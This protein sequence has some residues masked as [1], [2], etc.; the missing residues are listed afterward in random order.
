MLYAPFCAAKAGIDQAITQFIS[1]GALGH[2]SGVFDLDDS[3]ARKAELILEEHNIRTDLSGA[4]AFALCMNCLEQV[5]PRER[6]VVLNTGAI[7][8]KP[9]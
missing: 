6:I 3:Q 9:A 7:F 4:A 1:E 5:D 2:Q 8:L